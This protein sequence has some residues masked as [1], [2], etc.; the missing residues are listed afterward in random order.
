MKGFLRIQQFQKIMRM[1]IKRKTD[2]KIKMQEEYRV[3]IYFKFDL[4]QGKV[5]NAIY[6][7]NNDFYKKIQN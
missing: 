4:F 6:L 1:V 5:L 2:L 3:L 7:L